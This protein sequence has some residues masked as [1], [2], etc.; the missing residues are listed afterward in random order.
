MKK[1]LTV[2]ALMATFMMLGVTAASAHPGHTSCKAFGH[3]NAAEAKAGTLV[4]ELHFFGPGVI[5]DVIR[6]VH[7]GGLFGEFPVPAIC[8]TS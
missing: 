4:E 5:D 7:S 3:H 2:L 8:A 6:L 1:I